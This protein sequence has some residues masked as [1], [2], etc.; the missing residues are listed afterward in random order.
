MMSVDD[1]LTICMLGKK[2]VYYSF[3]NN[4]KYIYKKNNDVLLTLVSFQSFL[5]AAEQNKIF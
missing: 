1:L 5:S 2:S 4:I 3:G